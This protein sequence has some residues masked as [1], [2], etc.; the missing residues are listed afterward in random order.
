MVLFS[1]RAVFFLQ[2]NT[3]VQFLPPCNDYI[4]RGITQRHSSARFPSPEYHNVPHRSQPIREL[5]ND[6]FDNSNFP[7]QGEAKRGATRRKLATSG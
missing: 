3:N 1:L 6:L 7:G 4:R 2:V 5:G